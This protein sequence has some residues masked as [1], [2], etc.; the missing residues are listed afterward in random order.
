MSRGLAQKKFECVSADQ[1]IVKTNTMT[2]L[3][4]DSTMNRWERLGELL[5]VAG[6]LALA[7]ERGFNGGNKRW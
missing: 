6:I 1:T 2:G 4:N 7:V 3:A 5:T